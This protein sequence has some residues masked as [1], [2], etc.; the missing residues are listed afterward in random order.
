MLY[1]E[2]HITLKDGQAALLRSPKSGDGASLLSH[3]LTCYDESDYLLNYPEEVTFTEKEEEV[4]INMTNDSATS[5]MVVCVINETITGCAMLTMNNR[6]KTK[7]R[8]E[9]AISVQKQYWGLGIGTALM[10]ALIETA[11]EKGLLQLELGVFADNER[12]LALYEKMGF[13]ATGTY[14]NAYILKDGS[15]HDEFFMIK[16]L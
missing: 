16:P 1:E 15:V 10:N 2:K 8:G 5:M 11:R 4:F 6:L 12:A 14:L 3:L 7:H 9:L 13:Y